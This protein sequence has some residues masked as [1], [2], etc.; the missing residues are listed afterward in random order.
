M[1]VFVVYLETQQIHVAL[2]TQKKGNCS[3]MVQQLLRS[4]F[5]LSRVVSSIDIKNTVVLTHSNLSYLA[6]TFFG[7]YGDNILLER[8]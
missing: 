5:N 6:F 4:C 2:F 1:G 3:R 7:G 8:T